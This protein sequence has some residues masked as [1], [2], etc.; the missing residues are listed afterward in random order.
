MKKAWKKY[1]ITI[2]LQKYILLDYRVLR[3]SFWFLF[4]DYLK[5][6]VY[7]YEDVDDG[8]GLFRYKL[9]TVKKS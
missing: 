4:R 8:T 6:A 7:R 1:K 3:V 5:T 2:P 9:E